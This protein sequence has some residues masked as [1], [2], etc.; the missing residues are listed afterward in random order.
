M[1]L[2]MFS[3]LHFVT[4]APQ[5]K[6]I[7][8]LHL[9]TRWLHVHLSSR[10][11]CLHSDKKW[12]LNN[13]MRKAIVFKGVFIFKAK[14]KNTVGRCLFVINHDVYHIANIICTVHVAECNC[15]NDPCQKHSYYSYR[16][17]SVFHT[18]TILAFP[19]SF[20]SWDFLVIMHAHVW[21]NQ[22]KDHNFHGI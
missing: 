12:M 13:T 9:N 2:S 15:L 11:D 14:L 10:K 4:E 8:L 3:L 18:S 19:V 21:I 1:W 16:R 20:T 5:S 6:A 17:E 7:H 22:N